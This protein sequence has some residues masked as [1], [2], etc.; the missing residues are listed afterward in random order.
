[1]P[2]DLSTIDLATIS[3]AHGVIVAALRNQCCL[4]K[5]PSPPVN[6]AMRTSRCDG[7][8]T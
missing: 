8:G 3:A 1:M 2:T 6:A 4:W 5:K 7:A